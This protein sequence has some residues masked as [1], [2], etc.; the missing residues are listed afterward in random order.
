MLIMPRDLG[1]PVAEVA[2]S[3]TC[4]PIRGQVGLT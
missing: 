2:L 3:G 1:D 4:E